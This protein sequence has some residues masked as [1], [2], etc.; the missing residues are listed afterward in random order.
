MRVPNFPSLAGS[1]LVSCTAFLSCFTICL[2]SWGNPTV[3][4]L[5][6]VVVLEN[7]VLPTQGAGVGRHSARRLAARVEQVL[8]EQAVKKLGIRASEEELRKRV[9]AAYPGLA[10]NPDQ[11]VALEQRVYGSLARGLRLALKDPGKERTIYLEVVKEPTG[12]PYQAW[13]LL[14][15]QVKTEKQVAALEAVTPSSP[16]DVYRQA[17][18]SVR[19]AML[20]EKLVE[21]LC[22][23]HEIG[24]PTE[25]E[26]HSVL[27]TSIGAKYRKKALD[28]EL[29]KQLQSQWHESQ[30]AKVY[31]RW[32]QKE[33]N[34]AKVEGVKADWEE[35]VRS[36][37]TYWWQGA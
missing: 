1:A 35:V 3:L 37:R 23:E 18:P 21:Q 19:N 32:L 29:K 8:V 7:E 30:K 9:R 24:E 34:N 25:D 17:M 4:R 14:L 16:E 28:P 15:K 22:K 20:L 36:L 5:G 31:R 33:F 12:Y 6:G 10:D 27:R 26:L 2:V 11:V 13:Q